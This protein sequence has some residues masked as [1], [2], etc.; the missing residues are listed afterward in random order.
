MPGA[1]SL[2]C[3][4]RPRTDSTPNLLIESQFRAVL[5]LAFDCR[6]TRSPMPIEHSWLVVRWSGCSV[7]LVWFRAAAVG[8]RV[9]DIAM[10]L[11]LSATQPRSKGAGPSLV[12]SWEKIRLAIPRSEEDSVDTTAPQPQNPWSSV[13]G[14][15]GG[16]CGIRVP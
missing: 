5:N 16:P 4:G 15:I 9:A 12:A 10:S 6:V 14:A 1:P 7:R 8:R 2:V 13:D 11:L 3:Q